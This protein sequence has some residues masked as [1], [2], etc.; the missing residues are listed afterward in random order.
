MNGSIIII[1]FY[2]FIVLE[3]WNRIIVTEEIMEPIYVATYNV[4]NQFKLQFI[5]KYHNYAY[6]VGCG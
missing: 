1:I 3:A 5:C 6:A 2:Y 4:A